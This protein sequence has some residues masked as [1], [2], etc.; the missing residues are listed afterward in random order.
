MAADERAKPRQPSRRRGDL[1]A[2]K[3]QPPKPAPKPPS[4]GGKK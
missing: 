3:K 4:F 1:A 2:V